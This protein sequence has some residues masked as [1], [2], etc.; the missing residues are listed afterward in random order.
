MTKGTGSRSDEAGKHDAQPLF[1]GLTSQ[2]AVFTESKVYA[3]LP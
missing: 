1:P 3:D 2:P